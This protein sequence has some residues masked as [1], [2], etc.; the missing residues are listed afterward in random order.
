MS[1]RLFII[2]LSE[3]LKLANQIVEGQFLVILTGKFEST[4]YDETKS[5]LAV[6]D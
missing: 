3:V 2:R 5:M 1:L 6:L 4:I